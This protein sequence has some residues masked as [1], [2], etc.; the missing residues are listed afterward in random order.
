MAQSWSVGRISSLRI[1]HIP[2]K[3]MGEENLKALPRKPVCREMS[4]VDFHFLSRKRDKDDMERDK[5]AKRLCL[6]LCL[7]T[8]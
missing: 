4:E 5:Q 6:C 1:S 8:F 2:G 3:V 7:K